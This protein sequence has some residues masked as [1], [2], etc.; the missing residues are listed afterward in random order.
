MFIRIA[1]PEMVSIGEIVKNTARTKKV[2]GGIRPRLRDRAESKRLR[3]SNGSRI[4]DRLLIQEVLV[5][6]QQEAGALAVSDGPG[7]GA[8]VILP[9][10]RRLHDCEGVA[11]VEDRIA[12]G[13]PEEA[14]PGRRSAVSGDFETG[15]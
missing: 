15:R 3:G 13:V 7:Y 6:R 14:G 2:M 1:D 8:F 11:R 12:S 10:L 5:E 4:D 9:A